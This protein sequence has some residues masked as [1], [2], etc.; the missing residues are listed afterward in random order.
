MCVC[1]C[2]C[3]CHQYRDAAI[4]WYYTCIEAFLLKGQL[5]WVHHVLRMP[6][7]RIPKQV[8]FGQ[9]A[10][11]KRPQCGP[12]RRYKDTLRVNLKQYNIDPGSLALATSDR[13][14]WQTLCHK[15]VT[16][17]E[18]TRVAALVHKRAVRKFDAQPSS[19]VLVFGRATAAAA[20][21]SAV[22]ESGFLPTRRRT[23]D[24]RSVVL[25]GAVQGVC[26]CHFSDTS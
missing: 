1:V 20:P 13:S 17:F 14:S 10:S 22:P 16:E 11:G 18:D 19:I 15:V 5:R 8:F 26:V 7:D 12:A 25:D 9:L 24:N 6:E 21:E 4:L 23:G 3:V 2:V